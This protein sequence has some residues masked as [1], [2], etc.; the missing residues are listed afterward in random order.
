LSLHENVFEALSSVSSPIGP[1]SNSWGVELEEASSQFNLGSLRSEGARKKRKESLDE[2]LKKQVQEM[3]RHQVPPEEGSGPASGPAAERL[4]NHAKST[5]ENQSDELQRMKLKNKEDI[6]KRRKA[7]ELGSKVEED[8][9]LLR[10]QNRNKSS[11]PLSA[12]GLSGASSSAAAGEELRSPPSVS[13][14]PPLASSTEVTS[15][16]EIWL[17]PLQC[18]RDA[19][20]SA[21]STGGKA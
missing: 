13:S 10:N 15:S 6:S 12:A 19:T 11:A 7:E 2:Q 1:K 4:L 14:V 18:L 21:G 5:I 17:Q 9:R 16:L 20:G 8:L 3:R